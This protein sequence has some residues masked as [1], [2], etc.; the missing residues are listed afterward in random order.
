MFAE[1]KRI[2]ER[3]EPF[4]FYT[5][6]ELW[7]DEHTSARMLAFHLNETL[8]VSSRNAKFIER[9]VAWI[10]SRFR[11]A[12]DT[13][14]ADFGC[15]PGL[16]AQQ[17]A[18]FQA[19][20]TGI[21]FSPRS[22]EYAREAAARE[23][24]H[25]NYVQQN[26]LDFDTADRFDLILMI[27]CDFCALSPT[28]RRGMLN[29]FHR[30]LK[31]RGSVLLDVYSLTAY[32]QRE[33]E[34]KYEANL[35]DGFWSSSPYY[36]FLNTFKYDPEKVVL[37]KYTIVEPERMRMVYNWLQYFTPEA[38]EREFAESGFSVQ[39]IHADVAGTPYDPQAGEFAVI[40]GR[41]PLATEVT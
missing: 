39:E 28:Q 31:P 17:L 30:L 33:E 35:F 19:Q 38:L 37:D 15:G 3:P 7:T 5:A 25:I 8:D 11:L 18:K 34:A 21:D 29:R 13:R 23:A 16:Y 2:N 12:T 4:A 32:A 6:G 1:L 27:M 24:L 26:Y 14:I 41:I 10:A 40:A 36:G 22:I 9:S 20:V